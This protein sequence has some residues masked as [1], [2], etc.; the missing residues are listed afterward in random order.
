MKRIEPARNQRLQNQE[1]TTE[2]E[3]SK[4][5]KM[6]YIPLPKNGLDRLTRDDTVESLLEPGNSLLRPDPVRSTDLADS[7]L[8]GSNSHT[9]SAHDDV[10]VHTEDTNSGVV[11]DTKVNVLLDTETEVTGLGEVPPPQ[12][13]LLNLQSSLQNLLRLGTSDSNVGGNLFV[14]SDLERSDGVSSLGGDGSLTGE[15]LKDLGGTGKSVTRFTDGDVDDELLDSELLHRVDS[16]SLLGHFGG[17][18]LMCEEERR[19][20]TS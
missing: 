19:R 13:V 14:P 15:L 17:C 5:H 11:L 16:G 4:G 2:R 18:S 1:F 6:Q 10:E 20:K 8:P 3:K 7:V 12:L 9:R